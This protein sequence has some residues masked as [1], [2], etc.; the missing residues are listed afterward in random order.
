MSLSIQNTAAPA[1][2]TVQNGA[3][4]DTAPT[5]VSAAFNPQTAQ[6]VLTMSDGSQVP[7]A[8]F[9]AALA[10]SLGGISLAVLDSNGA[11]ILGGKPRFGVSSAGNL[12]VPTPLPDTSNGY[13]PATGSGEL[14]Q[15]GSGPIQ[16][17]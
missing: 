17:A 14:Y 11:L 1:A 5:I 7:I 3:T 2:V 13:A 6:L 15:N 16:E 10:Q 4:P 9:A 12:T 8:G